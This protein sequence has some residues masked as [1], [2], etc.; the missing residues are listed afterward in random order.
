MH[1]RGAMVFDRALADAEICG[2][3]LAWVAGEDHIHNPALLRCEFRDAI[4]GGGVPGGQFGRVLGL[5]KRA[6]DAGEQFS[7]ADR[8]F[9]EVRAPAFMACTAIGT[10]LFPVIMMEGS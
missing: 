1:D 5:F 8:L 10:S 6:L 7:A 3:I 4:R 9:E 2:D